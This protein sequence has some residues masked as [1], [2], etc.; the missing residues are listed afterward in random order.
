MSHILNRH[1][2]NYII[3]ALIL[4]ITIQ[5]VKIFTE[6][7][8]V[9]SQKK[10]K[11]LNK[12]IILLAVLLTISVAGLI[13]ISI[14]KTNIEQENSAVT[15]YDNIISDEEYN[16][17]EDKSA[18]NNNTE[19]KTEPAVTDTPRKNTQSNVTPP[20]SRITPDNSGNAATL[21][22]HKFSSDA[23]TPFE[24]ANMFPGDII[25]KNY[26][27]QVTHEKDVTVHFTA[28][29]REGYE[30]LAE[31]LKCKIVLRN[32]GATIYEGLMRDVPADIG[33]TIG[34][35]HWNTSELYYEIT[36]RLDT[37]VGNDYQNKMLVADFEWWIEAEDQP[38]LSVPDT[39]D[40]TNTL[41]WAGAFGAA[42]VI[43]FVLIIVKKKEETDE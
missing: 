40:S 1:I 6:G 33:Y 29:V 4:K 26:C 20:V 34:T 7:A 24:A 32:T 9:D 37:S 13:G 39:G 16:A 18:E 11:S 41:L 21:K 30:K 25:A 2:D 43:L 31:V 8:K 15:V 36:A 28:H 3:V 35:S 10:Q 19:N 42:G 12:I 38:N 22:L 23:N 17:A 27:V 5:S 14:Y